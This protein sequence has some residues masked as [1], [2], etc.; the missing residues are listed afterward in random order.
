MNYLQAYDR[1]LHADE[2]IRAM[3][4]T[5]VNPMILGLQASRPWWMHM[6]Y[7]IWLLIRCGNLYLQPNWRQSRGARIERRVAVWLGLNIHLARGNEE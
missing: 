4:L 7:D 3:G 6:A 2:E 5:P 1:F